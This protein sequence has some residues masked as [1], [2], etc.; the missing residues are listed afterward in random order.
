MSFASFYGAVLTSR[1]A[2]S[3]L[4]LLLLL[5][6]ATLVDVAFFTAA[7]APLTSSSGHGY[8]FSS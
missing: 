4:T 2:Y 6:F 1:G 7:G 3:E 5:L 8:F